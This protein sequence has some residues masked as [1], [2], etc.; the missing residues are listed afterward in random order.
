MGQR[1][2]NGDLRRNPETRG[3]RL[4]DKGTPELIRQRMAEH[5][6]AEIG[7][8][9]PLDIL[10]ARGELIPAPGPEASGEAWRSYRAELDGLIQAAVTFSELYRR[11]YGSGAPRASDVD[12]VPGHDPLRETKGDIDAKARFEGMLDA[13]KSQGRR[14]LDVT[15][16]VVVYR[17]RVWGSMHRPERYALDLAALRTGIRALADARPRAMRSAA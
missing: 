9:F 10:A 3:D 8:D 15:K 4:A 14:V 1:E 13:L 2:A 16:R 12:R 6:F 17:Q 11:H 5:G 7:S